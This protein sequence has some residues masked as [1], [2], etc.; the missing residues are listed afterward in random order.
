[1]K[2]FLLTVKA[3][4]EGHNDGSATEIAFGFSLVE[5]V[6]IEIGRLIDLVVDN[7]NRDDVQLAF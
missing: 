6:D 2:S 3:G 5:L 7:G 1:M 4:M